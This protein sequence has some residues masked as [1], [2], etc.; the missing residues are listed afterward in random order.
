MSG[1]GV[2]LFHA[3]VEILSL[4]LRDSRTIVIG[5]TRLHEILPVGLV[6]AL[7]HDL[8]VED[9]GVEFLHVE[10]QLGGVN[11]LHRLTQERLGKTRLELVAAIVVM[12]AVGEPY[13]LEV[14]LKGAEF[15]ALPVAFEVCVDGL[16]ELADA[17]VVA[18]VLVPKNIPSRE[19]SLGKEVYEFFLAE[20]QVVETV[21][22]IAQHLQIG[23][24]LIVVLEIILFC[25]HQLCAGN[26]ACHE[27]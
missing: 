26:H 15:F 22:L 18:P 20:G 17:Q 25:L 9:D 2:C 19:R 1:V 13:T 11:G 6:G 8:R 12:N 24:A 3:E 10:G 4:S 21:D 5:R 7:G 16:Q 23:K 27:Q 14:H